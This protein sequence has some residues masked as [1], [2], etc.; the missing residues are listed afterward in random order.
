MKKLFAFWVFCTSV[1]SVF[2]QVP[3][4]P[5]P[6]PPL[7]TPPEEEVITINSSRE[8]SEFGQSPYGNLLDGKIHKVYV[9]GKY[10]FARNNE[11]LVPA[12]YDYVGGEYGDFMIVHKHHVYGAID[13]SNKVIIPFQ[14]K[15]IQKPKGKSS[16]VLAWSVNGYSLL[17]NKGRNI[18]STEYIS[19]FIFREK[20][21][22]LK[23]PGEQLVYDNDG[24][25]VFQGNFDQLEEYTSTQL[26][27]DDLFVV[28]QNGL[29]GIVN[30]RGETVL[31]FRNRV[32]LWST[33]HR[34]GVVDTL[35]RAILV[36]WTG[37]EFTTAKLESIIEPD[38]NG[39]C[40][41]VLNDYKL[42][43]IDTM[44][45]EKL[46]PEYSILGRLSNAD[47]FYKLKKGDYYGL[48]AVDGKFVIPFTEASEIRALQVRHLEWEPDSF[49]VRV[50]KNEVIPDLFFTSLSPDRQLSLWHRERGLILKGDFNYVNILSDEG[51]VMAVSE[52]NR[53]YVLYDL[54]GKVL[55]EP[56]TWEIVGLNTAQTVFALRSSDISGF[57][58]FQMIRKDGSRVSD[59]WYKYIAFGSFPHGFFALA[60][61]D[62]RYAL[63]DP[64]GKR[65][66]DH[67][68]SKI[69]PAEASG[70]SPVAVPAG[71]KI[72]AKAVRPDGASEWLDHLGRA[73]PIK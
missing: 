50:V 10:G 38:K 65:L 43:L 27:R 52:K 68:Y 33:E 26:H 3:W 71:R 59:E 4:E 9:G 42:G 60:V 41:A 25:L 30:T 28:R 2:S 51:P 54:Q 29:Q 5:P 20:Y 47:R 37:K 8:I 17:D 64:F 63:F 12:E 32:I 49:G 72:I 62:R 40:I 18:S 22:L 70:K 14:Y 16:V 34:L 7:P 44:G 58:G 61:D 67:L 48:W 53:R 35:G 23:R 69:E 24:K 45:E 55:A 46:P 73:Y 39:L 15:L 6:H 21:V 19:G 36:D 1:C 56:A 57:F 31:P 11:L 66:T 13:G